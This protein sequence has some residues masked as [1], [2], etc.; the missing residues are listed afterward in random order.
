M[1]SR[2]VADKA[3]GRKSPEAA[4]RLLVSCGNSDRIVERGDC[5]WAEKPSLLGEQ[6][7]LGI[8]DGDG[9]AE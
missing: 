1:V 8:S 3:S 6:N 5:I 7:Q 9:P 4:P 2:N